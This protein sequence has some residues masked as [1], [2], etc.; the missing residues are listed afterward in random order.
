MI[1]VSR[2]GWGAVP[3][4]STT[5]LNRSRI[6]NFIVHYSGA[7]RN[8][9]VRSI[10]RFCM[11]DKGHSDIDYNRIVRAEFDYMGRGWNVG[12]HTL[13]NNSNS[14]GVCVIGLDGDATDEDMR[15]V[16]EIY[17]QVCG[18]LGRQLSKTDHRNLLGSSYTSCPGNELDL[19]VDQGMP[20]PAGG[21]MALLTQEERDR[22]QRVL[23]KFYIANTRG[24]K[25]FEDVPLPNGTT[26]TQPWPMAEQI[27]AIFDRPPV[28]SAPV[29]IPALV[30]ALRPVIREEVDTAVRAILLDGGTK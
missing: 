1:S 6:V 10:Q 20:Y 14:Y 11:E 12:G 17:D 30:A 18:E 3:P 27:Q 21:N 4:T 25:V 19:W 7:S 8:Q 5:P 29:D 24:A 23:D 22:L 28:A 13:N 16:R 15:T 26:E 9:T 2:A